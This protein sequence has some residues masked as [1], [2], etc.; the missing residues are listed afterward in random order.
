MQWCFNTPKAGPLSCVT[1]PIQKKKIKIVILS[2]L[3]VLDGT[4]KSLADTET[5]C[6]LRS[7]A[8]RQ[9]VHFRYKARGPGFYSDTSLL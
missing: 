4:E 8:R 7:Q 1:S 2:I 3:N 6:S 5:V 9:D